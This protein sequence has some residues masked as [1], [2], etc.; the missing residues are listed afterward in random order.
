MELQPMFNTA[1]SCFAMAIALALVVT[2]GP[3]FAQSKGG[4]K[5][6]C[7]KDKSG[8]VVGCG[9]SVPPEYQT[10]ATKELDRRGVTRKTTD[11]ADEVAKH[12]AR[13]EEL[14]RQKTE[15]Q[16]KLAEQKRQ[17]SALI[18]TFAN[19]KE[20]D[21]KRD[22]DLQQIDLQTSQLQTALKSATDRYN[23]LKARSDAAEKSKKPVPDSQ[24]EDL[25]RAAADKE[26]LENSIAAKDKEKQEIR[27]RYADYRKRFAELKE[28]S[29]QAPAPPTS[30]KPG[31][32]AK[33]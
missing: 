12:R 13:D 6:V 9:D 23:A 3:A 22:R 32:A 27:Q 33:K 5:I 10:S 16:K 26:K 2:A 21:A 20:I 17:D 31:A 11:S 7:W 30:P 25:A 14:A 24:K 29:Q 18:N 1:R 15:E 19:E 28:G 4:G 8:K